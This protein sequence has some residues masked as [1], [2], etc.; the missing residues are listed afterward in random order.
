MGA[1]CSTIELVAGVAGA[2]V[3]TGLVV[4]IARSN[5]AEGARELLAQALRIGLAITLPVA[6]AV[7]VAGYALSDY[8][9]GGKVAPLAYVLAAAAGW[10]AVIPV[11]VNSYWMGRKSYGLMLALSV[12]SIA[13]GLAAVILLREI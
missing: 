1:A 5:R 6:A 10:M 13:I 12:A 8:L 4:Y 2:G 7:G 11:L 9:T 3:G